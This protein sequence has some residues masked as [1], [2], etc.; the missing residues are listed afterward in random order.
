MKQENVLD[1]FSGMITQRTELD[2]RLRALSNALK[3]GCALS[4]LVRALDAL[5][6]STEAHFVEEEKLMR[7][8]GFDGLESHC[9][10][11]EFLSNRLATLRKDIL[12]NFGEEERKQLLAFLEGDF[13]YHIIQDLQ[14]WERREISAKFAY[15]RSKEQTKAA[16]RILPWTVFILGMLLN[17]AVWWATDA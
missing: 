6:E 4:D 10:T 9:R 16:M 1:N 11:H 2:G 12:E 5:V 8:Y 13:Q 14:A 3:D 17:A 15:Q 7:L